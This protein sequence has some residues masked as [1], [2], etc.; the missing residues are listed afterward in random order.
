MQKDDIRPLVKASDI[1]AA[2][3]LLTRLPISVDTK[4]ARARGAQAAWAYPLVGLIIALIALS[5]T[6]V[7]GWLGL[8]TTLQAGACL[9]I[10]TIITGAMHEDGLA[11]SADGL[12]GGWTLERRLEIMND[13][14]IGTYGVLALAFSVLLRFAALTQLIALGHFWSGVIT[15]AVL[16]RANMLSVM[17]LLPHARETGLSQSVGRPEQS[18]MLAGIGVALA[19]AFVMSPW[20]L[21]ALAI[22]S[23]LSTMACAAIA[24]HKINGQTGDI[25]GATQQVSEVLL[26]ATCLALVS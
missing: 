20:H 22:V 21:P 18:T 26:F 5:I 13:S 23:I 11:D 2:L 16:S 10:M 4:V 25:L 17:T 12:W 3:G 7:L 8:N 15:A 14:H 19:V 9:L 1:P 6:S 24:R